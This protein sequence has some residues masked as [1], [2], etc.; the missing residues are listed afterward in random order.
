MKKFTVSLFSLLLAVNFAFAGGL[1]TN[2]NQSTAWARMLV[3][4]ASTSVDAAYYNPAGLT[5]LQDGLYISF[6]NQSIFQTQTVTNS[7]PYLNN[8]V[9]KGTVSAPVFPD[10]YVVYKNKRWA[11]SAGF[12]VIGGGGSAD[13]KKGIPMAEMPIS[14]LVGALGSTGVKG[15]S[16]DMAVKGTSIYYGLQAGASFAISDHVS[17][18][19]GLRYVM[20]KNAYTGHIKDIRLQTKAGNFRAD[21]VL[22]QLGRYLR[23]N[24]G[25]AAG[26]STQYKAAGD[27][28][29]PLLDNGLGGA[30]IS[31]AEAA[32]AITADQA[33]AMT[34]ALLS[35]GIPQSQ[36]DAMT[37]TQIQTTYYGASTKY[38]A[39]AKKLTVQSIQMFGGARLMRDQEI[40]VHQSGNGITPIL[41]VNLSFANDNVNIGIKYEFK[42]KITLTNS[43]PAGK[44]FV[45]GMNADGSP[46]EMFPNGGKVN[47]DM[48][49]MLSV[50]ARFNLSKV[51]SIQ[52]GYHTYW[53]SKTGWENVKTNIK[54]NSQEFGL[55][56]EFNV[57]KNF[58]LSCGYL[59]T[60]TGVNPSYQSDL[61]YSLNTNTIGAGGAFKLSKALTFQFGGYVVKYQ[62]QTVPGTFD[63]AGTPVAYTTKY[64]K[65]LWGI[66]VGLDYHLGKKK[67]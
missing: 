55:G 20:V 67:K 60:T 32:G 1:V 53:D 42:T 50:G 8:P 37:M 43:T 41:G 7:F 38:A 48:P 24:A 56:A 65:N 5:K 34:N 11:F 57:T 52:A 39:T 23:Y 12:M 25:L 2:T 46:I 66:S 64:E 6:S 27:G 35:L 49:A 16:V 47:A 30:T 36:I 17:V 18:Y 10:L 62:S 4:D 29:T 31:Q 63:V 13:F 45:I 28:I 22:N 59:H 14:S 19:A 26:A 44:G 9:F 21:T 40:D 15:Y 61:S 3:R 51:V 54:K 33:T 58:L